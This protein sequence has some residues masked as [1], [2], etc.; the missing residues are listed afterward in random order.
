MEAGEMATSPATLDRAVAARLVS[1]VAAI[2]GVRSALICDSSGMALAAFASAEP[3]RDA[4]LASFI[5]LRAEALPV[6]GDLRGMGRQLAGSHFDHV[7]ISGTG[8]VDTFICRASGD[9]YLALTAASGR[10]ATIRPA[11]AQVLRR[12]ALTTN[13]A[14]RR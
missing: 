13:P 1:A 8:G 7:L 2:E 4:A 3:A 11:I 12:F 14:T 6:D 5:A 10:S 9:A